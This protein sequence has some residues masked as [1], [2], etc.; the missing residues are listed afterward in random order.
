MLQS[1]ATPPPPRSDHGAGR[2]VV[3]DLVRSATAVSSLPEVQTYI[4]C[5]EKCHIHTVSSP[6]PQTASK[7][8]YRSG[9]RGPSVSSHYVQGDKD[10]PPL[11]LMPHQDTIAIDV[12]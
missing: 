3:Q 9:V 2:N 6:P 1:S 7:K 5:G 12:S 8:K 11:P 4:N 10:D